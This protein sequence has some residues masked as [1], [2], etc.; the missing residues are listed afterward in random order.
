MLQSLLHTDMFVKDIFEFKLQA[1]PKASKIDL[2]DFEIGK[3]MLKELQDLIAMM[4]V[5]HHHQNQK[6]TQ[7]Q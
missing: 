4:L 1:K 5:M 7:M 3:V 6:S 2:E